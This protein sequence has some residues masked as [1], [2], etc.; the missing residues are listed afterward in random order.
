MQVDN[1]WIGGDDLET[2]NTWQWLD[3]TKFNFTNWAKNEPAKDSRSFCTAL[4]LP[5]GLWY[6]KSC[7]ESKPYVC[8]LPASNETNMAKHKNTSLRATRHQ[9][10]STQHQT[11]KAICNEG[12]SYLNA[13]DLCY[14]VVNDASDCY[15]PNTQEASIHTKEENA[16]IG[17]E[18]KML[19]HITNFRTRI[20]TSQKQRECKSSLKFCPIQSVERCTSNFVDATTNLGNQRSRASA[21]VFQRVT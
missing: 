16:F 9:P 5:E 14:K 18:A 6:A 15:R 20:E 21:P 10:T 19:S 11:I 7:Y 4:S 8:A 3:S 12:Y 17:G 13:T 2:P 1:F